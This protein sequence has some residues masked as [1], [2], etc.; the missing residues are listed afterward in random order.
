M[1]TVHGTEP[2]YPMRTVYRLTRPYADNAC[3]LQL[4]TTTSLGWRTPI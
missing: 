4:G 1:Y 3:R 2:G